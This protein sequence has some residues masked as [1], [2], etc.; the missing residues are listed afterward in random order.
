L[1]FIYFF[2]GSMFNNSFNIIWWSA[3]LAFIISKPNILHR[4]N[5]IKKGEKDHIVD[6]IY[7]TMG[8][9]NGNLKHKIGIMTYLT[10]GVLGWILFYC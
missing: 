10:G 7:N 4:T 8:I 5:I 6:E 9:K 2:I 1:S 3:L